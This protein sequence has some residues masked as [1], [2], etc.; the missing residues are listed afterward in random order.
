ML[1]FTTNSTIAVV[2]ISFYILLDFIPAISV[3]SCKRIYHKSSESITP[4][5]PIFS[6]FDG[7]VMS[8]PERKTAENPFKEFIQGQMRII[9]LKDYS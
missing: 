1:D 7:E 3:K 5:F 8:P 9:K 6:K 4:I 2:I